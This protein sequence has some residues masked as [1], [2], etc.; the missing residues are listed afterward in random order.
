MTSVESLQYD[1]F[2]KKGFRQVD[3]FTGLVEDFTGIHLTINEVENDKVFEP[4]ASRIKSRFDLFAEYEKHRIIV[5]GQQACDTDDFDR[6]FYY[7]TIA[8]AETIY[9]STDYLFPKTVL[10]LVFFTDRKTPRPHR[11]ILVQD[12]EIR[13]LD[14]EVVESIHELKHQIMYVF[15]KDPLSDWDV[16]KQCFEWIEAINDTLDGI[17]SEDEYENPLI[18]RLFQVISTKNTT[19]KE[20]AKMIDERSKQEIA[21]RAYKAGQKEAWKKA[22]KKTAQA[23]KKLG[24]LTDEEIVATVGLSVKEVKML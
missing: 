4:P 13:T 24:K 18:K 21:D 12:L 10:T 23:L 16:S 19:E 3:I 9:S 20:R 2:F 17:V 6:F 7:Q 15:T 11:N 22:Q 5:E 8:M 14:G 1:T